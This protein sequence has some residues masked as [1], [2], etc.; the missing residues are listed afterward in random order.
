MGNNKFFIQWNYKWNSS[1]NS[2][3]LLSVD[4]LNALAKL[5]KLM[6]ED[7]TIF[8]KVITPQSFP[9]TYNAF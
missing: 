2:N 1:I 9:K 4:F 3:F 8:R 7:L 5:S 6:G